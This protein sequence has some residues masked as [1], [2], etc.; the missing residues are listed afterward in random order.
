MDLYFASRAE[1]ALVLSVCTIIYI[2]YIISCSNLR[3]SRIR[4]KVLWVADCSQH[5]AL[6]PVGSQGYCFE[7]FTDVFS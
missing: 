1:F 2:A 4:L 7:E 3:S 5:G 6:G